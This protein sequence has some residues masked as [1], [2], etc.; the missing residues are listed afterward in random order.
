MMVGFFSTF[1]GAHYAGDGV[2]IPMAAFGFLA[3]TA[4]WLSFLPPARYR[5]WVKGGAAPVEARALA[6]RRTPD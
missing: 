4:I 5:A 1:F 6:P 2:E 3:A